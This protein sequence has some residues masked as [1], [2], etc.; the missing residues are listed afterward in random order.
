MSGFLFDVGVVVGVDC[1]EPGVDLAA[2][3]MKLLLEQ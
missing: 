3:N 1:D 2:L